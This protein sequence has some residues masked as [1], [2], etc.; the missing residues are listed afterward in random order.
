MSRHKKS[1]SRRSAE[2]NPSKSTVCDP[3]PN[4]RRHG[5][6]HTRN[7]RLTCIYIADMRVRRSCREQKSRVGNGGEMTPPLV[8]PTDSVNTPRG[9]APEILKWSWL[10]GRA[11]PPEVNRSKTIENV[12]PWQ[13]AFYLL[14]ETFFALFSLSIFYINRK[15][16]A[17]TDYLLQYLFYNKLNLSLLYYLNV[18]I[19]Y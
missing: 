4:L 19:I 1:F 9:Y 7:Q 11:W 15:K 8:D 2:E 13:P 5:V 14:T 17:K 6:T 10:R 3:C 16:P 18:K 12:S